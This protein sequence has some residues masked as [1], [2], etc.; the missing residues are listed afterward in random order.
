MTQYKILLLDADG[1][2]IL[3]PRLFSEIYCEKY[4]V[5]PILQQEFY[6]SKEFKQA[7]IGKFDL[8]IAIKLQKEKWKWDGSPDELMQMWFEAENYPNHDLLELVSQLRQE[9]IKVYLVTQQEKYRAKYLANNMFKDKLDGM[10]VTCDIGYSKND[11]TF[12]ETVLHEVKQLHPDI[13][14]SEIAY[15]DDRRPLVDLAS[16]TGIDAHIYSDNSQVK[17]V[18]SM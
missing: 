7:S 5:D 15:F 4:S 16:S 2:L 1:V 6:S 10:F 3:P 17:S 9:G 13:Q 18:L 14:V 8:R 12:W 11:I